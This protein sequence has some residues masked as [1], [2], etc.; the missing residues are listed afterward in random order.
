LNSIGAS[1]RAEAA[2]VVVAFI[3]GSTFVLVKAALADVSTFLFLTLRFLLAG[4]ILAIG[5]RGRMSGTFSRPGRKLWS[6]VL[7]GVFLFGGYAF[8]TV[9]LR[10]TTPSKSAFL[11]GLAIV[12]VPLLSSL[13]YR[14]APQF[15]EAFGAVVATTGMGL[16]TLEGTELRIGTGDLLTIACAI[17][18][19][20][21]MVIIGHY[22]PREGFERL[23][24]LQV[25]TAALLGLSVC[26]WL[27]PTYIR[28]TPIVITGLTVAGLLA[29][30][31]AF[32]IHAWAQ[33]HTSATRTAV[34]FALEPIFAWAT[35]F[36]VLR[37]VLNWRAAAGAILILSGIL[38]VEL[39]PLKI[40][41]HP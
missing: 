7:A 41:K 12:L 18:F 33:Q 3:W 36:V 8:Q 10:L 19:A 5:Y 1:G 14:I 11:T 29:T 9:G 23:S 22:A 31:A 24:V 16:M 6:G 40:V 37:E 34:I 17:F 20:F 4:F 21:H 38:I 27:E 30:A 26:W 28:W 25:S 32:T 39:K 15:R 13:V 35:S 2:L